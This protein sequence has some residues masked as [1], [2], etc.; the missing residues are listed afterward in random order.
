MYMKKVNMCPR[1]HTFI[2]DSIES[3]LSEVNVLL[4]YILRAKDWLD[5]LRRGRGEERRGRG[6][7]KG[8]GEGEGEDEDE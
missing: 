8:E 3:S 4:R 5:S 6:E 1:V 2:H 7:G